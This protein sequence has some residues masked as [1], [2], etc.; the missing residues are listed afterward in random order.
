MRKLG[1][2]TIKIKYKRIMMKTLGDVNN[3]DCLHQVK[4]DVDED[5]IYV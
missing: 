3:V 1:N 4:E 2:L 5:I